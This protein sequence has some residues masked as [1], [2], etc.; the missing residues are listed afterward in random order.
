[1]NHPSSRHLTHDYE[2]YKGLSLREL[3]SMALIA[4]P[5]TSILCAMGGLLIDVPLAFGC[6]GFIVGFVLSITVIPKRVAR[7]KAGK[8]HG[9]L[10][11]QTTK[12]LATLGLIRSPYLQHCGVWQ[13]SKLVGGSHV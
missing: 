13:T 10:M 2:A 7:L 1:M 8:P 4:T 6:V 12:Y 3:C 9:Y 5:L 11:K